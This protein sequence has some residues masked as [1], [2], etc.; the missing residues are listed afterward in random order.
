MD[1]TNLLFDSILELGLKVTKPIYGVDNVTMFQISGKYM[2]NDI[3][4]LYNLLVDKKISEYSY[5]NHCELRD[6][7]RIVEQFRVIYEHLDREHK[8]MLEMKRVEKEK[9]KVHH[10][11][12]E[13]HNVLHGS[14]EKMTPDVF[15]ERESSGSSISEV[16]QSESLCS[17]DVFE[18]LVPYRKP[19]LQEIQ[20]Y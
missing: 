18:G 7:E 14:E 9:E 5:V 2:L 19:I 1:K 11:L 20:I 15:V 4:V 17:D 12:S 8:Q 16:L 10:V 6:N 3:P 13:V